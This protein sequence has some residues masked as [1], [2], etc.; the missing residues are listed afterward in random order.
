MTSF[1]IDNERS[2][3][4]IDEKEAKWIERKINYD[5]TM[6]DIEKALLENLTK[7]SKY[8]PENL[9]KFI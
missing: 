8:L 4:E 6:L 5:V 3:G 7:K 2:K 9:K 1:V